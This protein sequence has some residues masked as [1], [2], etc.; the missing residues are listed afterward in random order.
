[1]A[2][3][4]K[5]GGPDQKSKPDF[6]EIKDRLE[7]L[8]DDLKRVHERNAPPQASPEARG[9]A[10][11]IAFRIAIELVTGV[12]LGGVIG[13]ALDNWLNTKPLMLI[14]FLLLGAAGGLLNAMRAA[15]NMQKN[16]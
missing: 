5:N 13:W 6:G 4:P 12:A 7:G 3:S 9:E 1:M 8:G 10:M 16:L 15:K 11:G 2:Q 14:I